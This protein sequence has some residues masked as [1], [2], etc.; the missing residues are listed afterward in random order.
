MTTGKALLGVLVGFAA[1]AVAGILLA[2]NKG[3][4][5]RKDFLKKGGELGD[6]LN[7]KI[8][9]KFDELLAVLNSR[10]RKSKV[11]NDIVNSKTELVD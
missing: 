2:P 1:G 4:R 11:Q 9:E 5:T 7:D 10:I 3:S 8:D 6:A